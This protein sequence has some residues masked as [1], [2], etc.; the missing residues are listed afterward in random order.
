MIKEIMAQ[1]P[2]YKGFDDADLNQLERLAVQVEFAADSTIFSKGEHAEPFFYMVLDGAV[3]VMLE[4]GEVY[5][6]YGVSGIVGEIGPVSQSKKRMR[7]VVAAEQ[8]TLLKWNLDD[9]QTQSPR[10]H[11][12]VLTAMKDLAWER[13]N[14][15]IRHV[16]GKDD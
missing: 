14:P 10:L 5:A 11:E 1:S 7:R 16:V 2:L 12:S 3:S 4:S 15:V 13:A 6:T 9:L 8:S